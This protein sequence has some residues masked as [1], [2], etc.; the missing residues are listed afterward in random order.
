MA[1]AN[2]SLV[3]LNGLLNGFPQLPR[4]ERAGA[5]DETL[6][7]IVATRVALDSL[8]W[9]ALPTTRAAFTRLAD[10]LEAARLASGVGSTVR[11]QSREMGR[12]IGLAIVA[13]SHGD[14]FDS[15]RGRKYVVPVGPGRWVNDAPANW[16][17]T[18]SVSGASQSVTVDNPAHVLRGGNASDRDLIL[19][20]PKHVGAGTLPAVNLAGVTEPY[21]GYNRPFALRRWNECESPAPPPFSKA[22]G[23]ALYREAQLVYTTRLGLSPEQRSTALYW[24]D[25][26]AESG[27]PGGHWLSIAGQLVGERRLSAEDAARL[28]MLTSVA[29]ADAFITVWGYKFQINLVRPRAYIRSVIDSTWEP[30]IPTPPFP[31]YMAGHSAISAAA[32]AV[33]TAMLGGAAFED[34]TNVALGHAVRRFASFT[35]AA[36][37]A[38]LS[39][40]Y[41]GIHFPSGNLVGRAVGECVGGRVANRLRAARRSSASTNW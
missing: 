37:E 24:A 25:N 15:T 38:G 18:Q 27:T 31:E 30:A 16:Y 4:A 7:A 34:S 28:M 40:I 2:A 5:I 29:V 35:A 33:M 12:R 21:W 19:N 20:R 36:N 17:A 6:T 11:S 13:W 23:S 39:R 9:E 32:A 1:S 8:L 26:P 14:G 10:S 41:G 3:P 22:P